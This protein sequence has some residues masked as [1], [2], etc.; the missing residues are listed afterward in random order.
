M[1]FRKLQVKA[2]IQSI[3]RP[4]TVKVF[5]QSNKSIHKKTDILT[6]YIK[7]EIVIC[8]T[9]FVF[10]ASFVFVGYHTIL[11]DFTGL[12]EIEKLQNDSIASK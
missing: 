6:K 3:M 10:S 9:I 11:D 12:K 4:S 7:I 5:P 8:V 1:R 2:Y